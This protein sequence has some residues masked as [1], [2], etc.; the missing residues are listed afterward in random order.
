MWIFEDKE[1][2]EESVDKHY[3]FIYEITNKVNGRKYIGR[4]F[5]TKAGR[6]QVKGKVKKI[7]KESDWMDYYGSSEE[8]NID[9]QTLGKENF[10]RRILRLCKT[11]GETK[12]WEVVYQ[13][14]NRVL[15]SKLPN[16]DW[17]F[18]NKNIMMKFHRANIGSF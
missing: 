5:F 17:E 13:I 16:G 7:R 8:L 6:K 15:E 9:V 12:Y 4:K 10:E 3:G 11:I 18:Y 2:T 1:F 14:Q